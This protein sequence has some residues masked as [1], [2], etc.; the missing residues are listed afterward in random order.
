MLSF[1]VPGRLPSYNELLRTHWAQRARLKRHYLNYLRLQFN[2][3][4]PE[5]PE[6]IRARVDFTL[7][8]RRRYDKDNAE[9]SVKLLLDA[10]RAANLI[11]Q[12]SLRWLDLTVNQELDRDNMRTEISILYPE[13][14]RPLKGD[15]YVP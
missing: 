5:K 13:A 6:K 12:D 9:A 2:R 15:K 7:Y 8:L 1:T 14:P 10:L 4:F 3:P 11:Y